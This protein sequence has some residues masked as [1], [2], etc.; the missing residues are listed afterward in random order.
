MHVNNAAVQPLPL[1][2]FPFV[3]IPLLPQLLSSLADDKNVPI[4]YSVAPISQKV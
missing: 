3:L 2:G 1:V 4:I